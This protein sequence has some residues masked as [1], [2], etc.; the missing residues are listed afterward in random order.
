MPIV[1]VLSEDWMLRT[2]VRAELREHGVEAMGMESAQDTGRVI[3]Q[4][5][6]PA[7]LVIDSKSKAA[8]D[9]A[10]QAL[11]GRVSTILIASRVEEL[12]EF[13]PA[14]IVSRPVRVAEV[15]D[16][17]LRLLRGTAA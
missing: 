1:F 8:E 12:P 9:P 11:A 16:A 7:V 3:A 4:G 14:V 13:R 6:V 15:T 2:A 10:I 17:V 5:T